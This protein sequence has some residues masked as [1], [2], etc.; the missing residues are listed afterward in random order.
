MYEKRQKIQLDISSYIYWFCKIKIRFVWI[1]RQKTTLKPQP[2]FNFTFVVHILFQIIFWCSEEP[3]KVKSEAEISYIR[4]W[5][6]DPIG[7]GLQTTV[8]EP[9]PAR[10]AIWSGPRRHAVNNEK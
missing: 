7:K 9:N 3:V 8:R 5:R 4:V 2:R 1:L 10:E 6:L